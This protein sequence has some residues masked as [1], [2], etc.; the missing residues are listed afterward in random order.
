MNQFFE[1]LQC[2]H[3]GQAYS[4]GSACGEIM[5]L[6][7]WFQIFRKSVNLSVETFRGRESAE[8]SFTV[9][10]DLDFPFR[11]TSTLA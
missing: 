11:R 9:I 5:S 10:T 2:C 8:N 3:D 4:R 1:R 7:S 6:R